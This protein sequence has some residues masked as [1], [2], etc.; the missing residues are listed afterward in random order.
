MPK[1]I[2]TSREVE[3]A[4]GLTVMEA[5]REAGFARTGL[6]AADMGVVELNEGFASQA[7]ATL[8][9][10]GVD[11]A[12]PRVNPN[13]GAIA[14]GHPLGHPLGMSG[15]GITLSAAEELQRGGARH[16]LAFM[17]VGVGLILERV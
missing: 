17:R 4:A 3:A 11:P 12:D 2:I 15:A 5:I 10:L 9:D 14:L 1:L 7:I 16:A 13:G 6:T 8:R